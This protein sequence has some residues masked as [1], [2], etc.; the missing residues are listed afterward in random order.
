MLIQIQDKSMTNN[1]LD[2]LKLKDTET[3]LRQFRCL[4]NESGK[5]K[6]I[7]EYQDIV[8]SLTKIKEELRKKINQIKNDHPNLNGD[9]ELELNKQADICKRQ[10]SN[11]S[12]DIEKIVSLKQQCSNEVNEYCTNPFMNTGTH[13]NN[14]D[15]LTNM[16]QRYSLLHMQ[17]LTFLTTKVEVLR[18]IKSL[19]NEKQVYGE[20]LI[21]EDNLK[22]TI[23]LCSIFELTL[24]NMQY[25]HGYFI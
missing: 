2:S 7:V 4:E 20:L 22:D 6:F 19:V 8:N 5:S 1:F 24:I 14:S 16:H 15:N 3:D 12:V 25:P 11:L 18:N 13:I 9:V 17:E 10:I 21:N 23:K